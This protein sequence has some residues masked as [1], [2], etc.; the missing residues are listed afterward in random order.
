MGRF[1]TFIVLIC[2]SSA[3]WAWDKMDDGNYSCVDLKWFTAD[4]GSV[5]ARETDKLLYGVVVSKNKLEHRGWKKTLELTE[6][7]GGYMYS[8][9]NGDL[10]FDV[11]FHK[12]NNEIAINTHLY[13]SGSS[14][15]AWKGK[16]TAL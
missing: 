9:D 3:S 14:Y 7:A 6:K 1:V 12:H 5:N 11:T 8:W 2:L 4:T 16:C 13:S 15:M 10:H